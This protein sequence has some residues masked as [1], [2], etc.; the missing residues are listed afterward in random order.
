MATAVETLGKLEPRWRQR[1]GGDQ[2]DGGR[3]R[4]RSL[5]GGFGNGGSGDTA[6]QAEIDSRRTDEQYQGQRAQRRR[7]AQGDLWHAACFHARFS[8][9]RL[10]CRLGGQL[11]AA[12]Q[13]A[14]GTVTEPRSAGGA[15][16]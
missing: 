10:R 6:R 2:R 13:T 11:G 12:N 9:F 5:C 16:L 7:Q 1:V 8:F 14:R 4:H 3:G 15:D